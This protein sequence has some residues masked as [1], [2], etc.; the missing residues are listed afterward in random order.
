MDGR[1]ALTP[2]TVLKLSTKTGYR[3]YTIAREIGRGGTCIVYD[4]SYT[5]NLGN[6]KLVRIK[7]SYP[8]ALRISRDGDGQLRA[9]E[10][11]LDA[12]DE[13]RKRITSGYQRNHDLFMRS[14]LTN[15]VSNNSDIYT[16]NNTVYIVSVYMNG[17]TFADFQGNSLHDCVSLVLG[18]ARALQRVHEAGYLYLDL[19]PDNILTISGSMDLV[20][21]FDFDSVISMEELKEAIRDNDPGRLRTSYTRGYAPLEQQTGRLRQIGKHTDLFSLGAVLFS[22]LWGRVPSAFDCDPSAAFDYTHMTYAGGGYQ[23]A[24]FRALTT[25]FH[26]TLAS[27]PPDRYQDA[28]EAVEQ[29][30][31]I[32]RLSDEMKPWLRSTPVQKPPVFYGREK[33]LQLLEALLCD[34][35]KGTAALCGMGG[36]GKSVLVRQYLSERAGQ[37]DAVVWLYDRGKISDVVADDTQVQINT[38]RRMREESREEYLKRK[39]LALSELAA[40]QKILLIVDN[41]ERDHLEQLEPFRQVGWTVLLISREK[42][43]EGMFPSLILEEMGEDALALLFAHYSHCS[44]ESEEDQKAFQRMI[45]RISGHTLLTELLARQIAGSFLSIREADELTEELGLNHLPDEKIDYIRDSS[46]RYDSLLKILDR[47][48]EKDHLS[49]QEK[50]GMKLLAL[51]D[52]PGIEAELFS[53]LAGMESL[54][55]VKNL[56]SSGW[57]KTD[58]T[59]LYLHPMMQE[60]VRTWPWTEETG[61]AADE[62]MRRLYD[63]IRPAGNRHDGSKQ[64]P[65]DYAKLYGLLCYA[66]QMIDHSERVTEASQRLLY[67][68]LMDAPVDQDAPILFRM[69]DLLE[70]SRWLDD[71]SILRL[72][73][74][75]AYMRARLYAPD[76]A[77]EILGQMKRY[78]LRHP[79]AYYLSAYHRAMAVILHNA[80]EYGNLKRCLKHEEK[81]VAAARMS[82]HPEAKKQLAASL[83]D[84]AT[85]LLSADLDREQ[86]RRLIQEAKP[87]VERYAGETDDVR[88]QYACNAAMCCAMEGKKEEAEQFLNMADRIAFTSPDSDLA[89]AEHLIEQ[90]APIRIAMEQYDLAEKAVLDAMKLCEL[91]E[92]AIRYRETR[93]DACLF[94][95][96]IYAMGGDYIRAEETFSEAEKWV[97]DS[98]YEWKLPLCPEEIHAKA[99]EER[100]HRTKGMQSNDSSH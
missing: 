53:S 27:Y 81:A 42:M 61:R 15:M 91:H 4:A 38:I 55:F 69:L 67:R 86:A 50:C 60:Y 99:E 54:D 9:E 33:E 72:Y 92:E 22:A 83:L 20:Q 7:E 30:S 57:L 100:K 84:K 11:D 98:P 87:L 3:D 65:V 97:D 96:R 51:F 88:Y 70:D 79:S 66:E 32:L 26:R 78:L 94:L 29:L 17:R 19:K 45:Q 82:R 36:I 5:D 1:C 21:L 35:E 64:F 52:M 25:F 31:E 18:A 77:I 48:V 56:E 12:F 63:R 75:A 47:L 59:R 93:F 62:M 44:L 28:G 14:T 2:G 90:A 71:D 95:G 80:D 76:D 49:S 68:L 24:L 89:S 10:R 37:W 58:D 34:A 6:Y 41:F 74:Q 40:K 43:P 39:L 23:D 46:V 13:A 16:A 73:E 8:Y 85:T